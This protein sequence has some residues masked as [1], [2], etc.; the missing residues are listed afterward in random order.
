M[1]VAL[2]QLNSTPGDIAGNCRTVLETLK[3]TAKDKPELL[4]F[5]ELF[6]L[7]YPP[8]DLLENDWFIEDVNSAIDEI[9]IESK[10]YPETGILL[11]T[12][13]VR[14]NSNGGHRLNN[15]A[16]LIYRGEV[17]FTHNKLLLP[18][19][20]IFD[21]TRYFEK[22]TTLST[23]EFR[24]E[25]LGITVCEDAWNSD[26]MWGTHKYERDPIS[27][28]VNIG[29]TTLLN[30]SA[31][32]FHINKQK[33]RFDIFKTHA[34]KHKLPFLLVNTV[35][36]N[37]ELIFDGNSFMFGKN[38]N[39]VE[40]LPSF[41]EAIKI[42]DT[43]AKTGEI[44]PPSFN[45]MASIHDALILGI[46]DY[47]Q[48]CG[49]Q[50]AVIGLSG[51]IDSAVTCALAVEALGHDQVF[52]ITM[53]SEYSSDGSVSDSES[54]AKNLKIRCETLPIKDTFDSFNKTL[55][56]IFKEEKPDVT[57]ENLQARIRGTLLMAFSNKFGALL[58]TTGNKSEMAVGYCTLY[59]DM[60]GGLAVISDLYKTAVYDLARYINRKREIIPIT[61]IEKP[62]SAELRP[63]QKDEDSLPPYEDL[64]SIL[65]MLIEENASS[66]DIIKKGYSEEVV[67]WVIRAMAINEYKRKQA[68]PG[69]KI[70]SKAFGSGRRFPIAAKYLR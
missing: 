37:D 40:M 23:F 64:D 34:K 21:E 61:T 35:G 58:L 2:C 3:N 32:P 51:G 19:Y 10:K 41:K 14:D 60:N 5:P 13:T 17:V 20:D 69:L 26:E 1:R 62:P 25:K 55:N 50:R 49:F 31:S 67:S 22:A 70:T 12:A 65:K 38:S 48:K 8:R 6:L 4:M 44:N 33:A 45:D 63:D 57:E 56:P 29:A 52:G 15:S 39:L 47:F 11:G 18:T 53:P 43:D 66:Y 24:G 42:V 7:G 36:G 9:C 54:L 46:R 27:E 68:A 30:I 16:V 59:G 28:L